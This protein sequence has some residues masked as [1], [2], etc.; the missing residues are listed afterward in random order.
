MNIL[1]TVCCRAG[2]KG[3]KNKNFRL[4]LGAPIS[5]YTLASIELYKQR[6][7]LQDTID[8]C[9]NTDSEDL[10]CQVLDRYKDTHIIR[11]A[12]SLAG[13]GREIGGTA[14]EEMGWAAQI[15]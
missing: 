4:F 10:T 3:L 13:L 15:C 5:Y 9:L 7:G 14:C 12:Q 2:S 11:R 1:F 8:I 6:Y